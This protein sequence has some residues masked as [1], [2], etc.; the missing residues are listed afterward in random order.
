MSAHA[1]RAPIR[2]FLVDDHEIVRRGLRDLAEL[3][4]DLEVVGEA[5]TVREGL[6]SIFEARPNVAILDVRLPDGDG[7]QLCREI[8]SRDPDIQCLILTSFPDEESMLNAV[9]AG[10]AGFLLKLSTGEELVEAVRAVAGGRSLLDPLEPPEVITRLETQAGENGL[11]AL[12][13]EERNVLDLIAEGQTNNEIAE[14]LG[15]HEVEVKQSVAELL[16]K[17]GL[18][19]PTEAA[20]YRERIRRESEQA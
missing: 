11:K 16:E 7:V 10:A 19:T 9:I 3:E 17:L 18:R 6:D 15:L 5:A 13:D 12:S 8:R 1:E 2:M 14:Q 4:S 20:I